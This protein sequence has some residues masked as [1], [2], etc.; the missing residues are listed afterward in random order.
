M[1]QE[2]KT[3]RTTIRWSDKEMA[4][5]RREMA[6]LRLT[7]SKLIRLKTVGKEK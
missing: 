6:R 1:K 7:I 3:H 4:Y 5:L 2:N